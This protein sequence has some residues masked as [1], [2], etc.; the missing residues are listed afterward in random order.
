LLEEDQKK[1]DAEIKRLNE[2]NLR[3][4]NQKNKLLK[5]LKENDK[6]RVEDLIPTKEDDTISVRSDLNESMQMS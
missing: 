5:D 1:K 4:K 6:L 3:L 2:D